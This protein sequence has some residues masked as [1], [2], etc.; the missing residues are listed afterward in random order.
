MVRFEQVLNRIEE[1]KDALPF[2][3]EK[4]QELD[5]LLDDLVTDNNIDVDGAYKLYALIEQVRCV[6]ESLNKS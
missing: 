6:A 4:T 2:I 3:V 1:V 5:D